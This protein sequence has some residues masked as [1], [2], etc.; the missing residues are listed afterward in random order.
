M[1]GGPSSQAKRYFPFGEGPRNC[2][3]QNFA[4]TSML[5]I[6]ATL[7]GRLHFR[8]AD[9]VPP[10]YAASNWCKQLVQDAPACTDH[11]SD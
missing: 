9:Q 8:L 7:L 3:G 2:L 4:H 1:A 11:T 6:L 5:T 10:S